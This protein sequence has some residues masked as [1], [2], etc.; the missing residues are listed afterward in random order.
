MLKSNINQAFVRKFIFR[1][2]NMFS[3][4]TLETIFILLKKTIQYTIFFPISIASKFFI[5]HQ[6]LKS[7]KIEA[8]QT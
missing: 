6:F 1:Y 3:L 5:N 4:L 2:K 8:N 7:A